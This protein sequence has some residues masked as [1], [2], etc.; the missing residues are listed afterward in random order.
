MVD[1]RKKPARSDGTPIVSFQGEQSDKAIKVAQVGR[2]GTEGTKATFNLCDKTTWFV[3]S[4]RVSETLSGSAGDTVYS[5]SYS[6]WIN[7]T[8]GHIWDE[9]TWKTAVS[10]AYDVVVVVNDVTQSMRTPYATSGGDYSVD[11]ASGSITFFASQSNPVTCSY[12]YATDSCFILKPETG[13][14]L[15]I[16]EAEVQFSEDV[17]MNDAVLMDVYGYVQVFAP[18]LWD[19]NGG[20]YPLNTLIPI[21]S[22]PYKRFA[23]FIDEALGSY[24]VIPAIGGS[25][26]GNSKATYGFP[27]K[28][29]AIRRLWHQYGM[30]LRI[31]LENDK[32]FGGERATATF[33]IVS[34]AESELQ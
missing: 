32:V 19:G 13:M 4:A 2:E 3:N 25:E 18:Q 33:Y 23:Q 24:P 30:E 20:P 29:G 28:Y 12:S 22:T 14:T 6:S 9:D 11:H 16:E 10:H 1:L 7:M 8:H 21:E 27:F 5:G 26:R 34:R 15:D 31:C 17:V